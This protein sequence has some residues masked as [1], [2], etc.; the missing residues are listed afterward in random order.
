MVS[1]RTT[2]TEVEEF[3]VSGT[4]AGRDKRVSVNFITND[5]TLVSPDQGDSAYTDGVASLT[6]MN[7][8]RRLGPA[9]GVR[10]VSPTVP[11]GYALNQN[12]PN[13]FNPSTNI[14]RPGPKSANP[15]S[16]A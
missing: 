10:Q 15:A 5:G 6:A 7:Y 12:Y 16:T 14:S 3:F 11:D 13:P 9:T 8:S 2:Q 4:Y 1:L